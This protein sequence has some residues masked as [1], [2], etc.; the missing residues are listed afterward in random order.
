MRRS[1]SSAFDLA[2]VFFLLIVTGTS[3]SQKP[4]LDRLLE[5][6][7]LALN[8]GDFAAA[9]SEFEQAQQLAPDN[10]SA[11]RG[12]MLSYVQSG[13][14]PEAVDLGTKAVAHWPNDGPIAARP[15]VPQLTRIDPA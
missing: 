13:R 15:A 11:N 1:G 4:E 14:L 5:R 10:L 8:A 2:A 7:Q 6:G 3:Q 9:T 12:L